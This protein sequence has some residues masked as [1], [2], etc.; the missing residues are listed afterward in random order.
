MCICSHSIFIRNRDFV[1]ALRNL[2]SVWDSKMRLEITHELQ[3]N[4][5]VEWKRPKGKQRLGREQ[6]SLY[7]SYGGNTMEDPWC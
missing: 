4:N 6:M 7:H 2:Q 3:K 5:N 1:S